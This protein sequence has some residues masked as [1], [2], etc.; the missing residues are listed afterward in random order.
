MM[1]QLKSR[2]VLAITIVFSSIGITSIAQELP[3]ILKMRT[4]DDSNYLPDFSFAGYHNGEV[5]IPKSDGKIINA[6]DYGV[7]AN[8]GLDDSKALKKLLMKLQKQ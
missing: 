4:I 1:T 3:E 8:D 7:I 2:F 6:S 5:K